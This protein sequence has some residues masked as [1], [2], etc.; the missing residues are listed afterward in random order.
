MR[1]TTVLQSI[2]STALRPDKHSSRCDNIH[3]EMSKLLFPVIASN[4]LNFRKLDFLG[5]PQR[6]HGEIR[7][8]R[9]VSDDK[10]GFR[11]I[12]QGLAPI[13]VKKVSSTYVGLA[14]GP[15]GFDVLGIDF[16]PNR[17]FAAWK[18]IRGSKKRSFA[19]DRLN[20][21]SWRYSK[22]PQPAAYVSGE[23]VGCL[24]ISEFNLFLHVP[25][26]AHVT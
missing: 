25:E 19:A 6:A 5:H 12:G 2:A 14:Y 10:D 26:H 23:R 22:G 8:P 15:C 1:A 4:P 18:A 9:R 11:K 13:E 24:E 21:R 20:N 17:M 3:S 7:H 16:E